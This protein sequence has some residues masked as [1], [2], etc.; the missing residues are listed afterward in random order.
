MSVSPEEAFGCRVLLMEIIRRAVYDWVLYRNNRR[1]NNRKFAHD[2]FVWLFLEEPGHPSWRLREKEGH[3]FFSF[4]VICE[5]LGLDVAQVR[6]SL[7]K[8]TP[9]D[10]QNIGRPPIRRRVPKPDADT[11]Y[12]DTIDVDIGEH[13]AE[14]VALLEEGDLLTLE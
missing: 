14:V 4:I 5:V 1:F 11:D 2:A 10:V 7:R 12:N 13:R 6:Q 8:I 3:N 9:Q